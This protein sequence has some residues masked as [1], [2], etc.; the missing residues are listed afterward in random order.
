MDVLRQLFTNDKVKDCKGVWGIPMEMADFSLRSWLRRRGQ[1]PDAKK[2]TAARFDFN[3]V[4]R[5]AAH[6]CEGVAHMHRL[7]LMHLDLKLDNV[8]VF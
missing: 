6:I 4:P 7:G 5:C 3:M 8:I 1:D 2:C